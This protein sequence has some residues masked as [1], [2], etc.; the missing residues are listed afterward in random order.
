MLWGGISQTFPQIFFSALL[1]E[2]LYLIGELECWGLYGFFG[3]FS[4]RS[5][6]SF[7]MKKFFEKKILKKKSKKF[8]AQLRKTPKIT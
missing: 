8:H 4:E 6:S 2:V 5:W 1:A 3:D 7:G